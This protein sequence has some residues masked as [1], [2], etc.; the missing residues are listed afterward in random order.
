MISHGVRVNSVYKHFKGHY[1]RVIAVSQSTDDIKEMRVVYE[2]LDSNNSVWNRPLTEFISLVPKE[3][4]EFNITGQKYRFEPV[5]NFSDKLSS[6]STDTL[7]DELKS[8]EEFLSYDKDLN[9]CNRYTEYVYG[10]PSP[11]STLLP[12]SIR[13]YTDDVDMLKKCL[14]Y[15]DIVYKRI[16]VPVDMADLQEDK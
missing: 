16:Y 8:R 14:H 13:G 4:Q 7:V 3:S 11:D 12:L 15:D 2:S 5:L 6:Y 10:K 1:Y 9:K